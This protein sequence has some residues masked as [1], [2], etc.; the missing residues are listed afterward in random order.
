MKSAY[1]RRSCLWENLLGKPSRARCGGA[2]LFI[3]MGIAL[4]VGSSAEEVEVSCVLGHGIYAMKLGGTT[5]KL[6]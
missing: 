2:P 3:H 4:I 6:R 1:M 5:S